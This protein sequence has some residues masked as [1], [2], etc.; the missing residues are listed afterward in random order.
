M[1]ANAAHPNVFIRSFSARGELGGL[2]RAA[3]AAV[4]AFD[5]CGFD[6]VI[7]ETVGTGQSE[8]AIVALAD[9]RVVVCP[10]GLGDDVQ[11]I[12]AGTLEIADVLAVSKG[13]LPLAEQT[14]REMREMLTLRRRGA[15]RRRGRRA[16]SSSARSP[17]PASTS[18]SARSTRTATRSASAA[19]RGC[20]RRS[21][22]AERRG[23]ARRSRASRGDGRRRTTSRRS[24]GRDDARRRRLARAHRRPR[25]QR[26]PVQDARHHLPRRRPGPRRSGDDRRR[27]PPQLQRRRPRR[28]D[29]RARR[30]GV[31]PGVELAR[32]GR[33][34]AS[35]R[36]SPSRPR[37]PPA[38]RWSRA[39][40]GAA[41]PPHRRLPHRRR[42]GGR[43]RRRDRRL[44]LHRH[45]LREGLRR[46]STGRRAD[47]AGIHPRVLSR[48]LSSERQHG[49]KIFL[50][51]AQRSRPWR[52]ASSRAL[53]PV[54]TTFPRLLLE[55]AAA[56]TRRAG[57]A[58]EG[59]RH[60]ADALVERA[61]RAWSRR[62]RAASREAGLKRGQHL[63]VIGENRPRLYASMLAAQSLGAIPV[64][65]YQDAAAG[66]FVFPIANAEVAFAIVEDQEQ[67]DKLL[68]VRDRCPQL[69]AHLVRRPAR[70]AQLPRA[71]PRLARR[72]SSRPGAPTRRRTRLLRERGRARRSPTTSRRCSSPRARPA[73]PRASSTR[74]PP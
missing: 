42:P 46:T 53:Q 11:A 10:P 55:H 70:P 54:Q 12:K 5:A 59:V 30:L 25:R 20:V 7:V 15:D 68:E 21:A 8:T 6:R 19:A 49:V 66:E 63:V 57:V 17:A 44:E 37:S 69:D 58:R 31:R 29:L 39:R 48:S 27:A 36:T 4:D 14:A 34:P 52:V 18:C 13:D 28:R 74:T 1:G 60:L 35:T 3:R 71:G 9:T 73:T 56:P 22:I 43:G 61:R 72:R 67:V 32:T 2:S 41:Q 47:P 23:A 16:S 26:R 24:V 62:S 40:R 50:K 38:T 65:L 51:S 45:G 64:P 33:G